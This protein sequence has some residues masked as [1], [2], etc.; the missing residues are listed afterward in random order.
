MFNSAT[1]TR[2]AAEVGIALAIIGI[3]SLSATGLANFLQV[4]P[5]LIGSIETIAVCGYV[6]L[7]DTFRLAS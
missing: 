6:W 4:H 3:I 2:F 5:I 7:T 1:V